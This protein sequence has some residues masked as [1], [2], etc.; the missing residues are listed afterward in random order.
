M[1][2]KPCELLRQ[3]TLPTSEAR[4]RPTNKSIGEKLTQVRRKEEPLLG[5]GA[6]PGRLR[7]GGGFSTAP[8]LTWLFCEIGLYTPPPLLTAVTTTSNN[9]ALSIWGAH[10]VLGPSVNIDKQEVAYY[11]EDH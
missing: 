3:L 6:E 4:P 1:T 5:G 8:G 2:P 11:S 7:K 10:L 9:N